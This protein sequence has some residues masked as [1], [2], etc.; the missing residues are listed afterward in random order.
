VGLARAGGE[1]LGSPRALGLRKEFDA[2][3]EVARQ[4]P[5]VDFEQRA[6]L[7]RAPEAARGEVELPEADGAV[8]A[9]QLELALGALALAQIEESLDRGVDGQRAEGGRSSAIDH[10]H[11]PHSAAGRDQGGVDGI[12]EQHESGARAPA[13]RQAREALDVE[14]HE[15]G[16]DGQRLFEAC[17]ALKARGAALGR[18]EALGDDGDE[19]VGEGVVR[20]THGGTP[21]GLNRGPWEEPSSRAGSNL[22]SGLQFLPPGTKCNFLKRCRGNGRLPRVRGGRLVTEAALRL[23]RRQI[24]QLIWIP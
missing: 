20:A 12:D 1:P 10:R 11:R 15:V 23:L 3:R 14:R 2:A 7:G 21:R 24:H 17:E 5:V 6:A 4:V 19:R 18:L 8:P 16:G 22:E 9:Q 13:L